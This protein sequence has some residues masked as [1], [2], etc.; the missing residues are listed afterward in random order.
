[1]SD[2]KFET[3]AI[4]S[5]SSR[6][7]NREHSVPIFQTSSFVFESAEQARALFSEEEE[8]LI[9]SRFSNPNC[10]EFVQKMVEMELAEDGISTASGMSAVFTTLAGLL[11]SG[12]HIVAS[13]AVFGSTHQLF[14]KVFPK[15][16]IESTYVYSNDPAEWKSAIRPNSKAIFLETP[17]NPGLDL[18]DLE[19]AGNLAKEN[20]LFYIVDNCFATPYLQQPIEY[21]ADVI[22]HSA[23]K[24]IDGQGRAV[25]GIIVGKKDLIKEIRFMARHSGPALAPFHAWLF[26]K[27]LETLAV[28]LDRACENAEQLAIFLENHDQVE[29]VKYPFLKSHPQFELAKKQ[30]KKGGALISFLHKDGLEG[31]KRF[32]D[33]IQLLSHTAN[34]GDTRTIVT[35]PASTTHS[36]LS[37]DEREQVGIFPGLIRVSVGLEHIND[38]IDAIENALHE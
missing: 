18:V 3:K 33:K 19:L 8:G 17:S 25:G 32:L 2:Y 11:K 5:Q 9:Y 30:M 12:D 16:S 22:V 26:S 6:T 35:H 37:D 13:G 1:M 21:G 38:I 29:W 24:F 23:T 36:K 20:N 31:G 27:S 28:R 7:Q 15:W 34:L 14:T 4:R 10:D